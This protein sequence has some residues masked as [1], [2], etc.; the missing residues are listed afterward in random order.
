MRIFEGLPTG[1]AARN[2]FMTGL[3]Y[4]LFLEAKLSPLMRMAALAPH[5][6]VGLKNAFDA[7]RALNLDRDEIP[8]TLFDLATIYPANDSELLFDF[9][10]RIG[11]R[12]E[13][14]LP[15]AKHRDLRE[16]IGRF[17]GTDD[18]DNGYLTG[19]G[20]LAVLDELLS[21]PFISVEEIEA[22]LPNR[23]RADFKVVNNGMTQFI[24]VVTVRFRADRLSS[25]QHV[26]EFLF[27]RSE[28]KLMD[29]RKNLPSEINLVLFPVIFGAD[30]I[31][32]LLTFR[33]GLL[34]ASSRMEAIGAFWPLLVGAFSIDNKIWRYETHPVQHL[35]K[36]S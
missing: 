14:R 7:H 31:E 30:D 19:L 13:K 36:R 17:V 22:I 4:T 1:H 5:D 12:I 8:T 34:G 10:L 29:K 21:M 35:L 9:G 33:E 23:K 11:E 25:D 16:T 3:E 27:K 6:L 15:A 20:E 32:K 2:A 26:E 28:Q 24:E 18:L